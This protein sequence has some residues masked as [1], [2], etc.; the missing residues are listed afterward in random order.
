MLVRVVT[1]SAAVSVFVYTTS[2]QDS[3][4]VSSTGTELSDTRV[5]RGAVQALTATP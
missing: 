1:V 3:T 5:I 4:G 2:S